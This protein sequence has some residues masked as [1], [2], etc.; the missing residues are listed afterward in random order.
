MGKHSAPRPRAFDRIHGQ[1]TDKSADVLE[2][3]TSVDVETDVAHDETDVAHDEPDV[4]HD[5]AAEPA[6]AP[7]RARRRSVLR[8]ALFAVVTAA[9]VAGTLAFASL[10]KSVKLDV[11]GKTQTV[12]T[13]AADVSG[14]LADSGV[15]ASNKD[16]V[17]PTKSAV[18]KDG[19]TVTVTHARPLTL[20]IDGKKSVKWVAALT[21]NEALDQLGLNDHGVSASRGTRIPVGGE[22]LTLTAPKPITVTADG[23]TQ[24]V[25]TTA[26]TA[27]EAIT[28]AGIPLSETDELSVPRDTPVTAGLQVS[29]TRVSLSTVTEQRVLP[30]A[31][32]QQPDPNQYVGLQSVLTAGVNG[33]AAVTVQVQSTNGVQTSRTDLATAVLTPPVNAVVSV[34]AKEFPAN[35]NALNWNALSMCESTNNPKAVNKTNGKYFGLYQFSVAT[36]ASVGGSGNPVDAAPEEQ[37]ARAKMLYM[38]SGAGQWECG[39]HLSD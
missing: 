4:A 36:W 1:T 30:Y 21:V 29:V 11:D 12:S 2:S 10:S 18:I 25:L 27:A 37:L 13:Y 31:T 24:T 26:T 3:A 19:Q 22:S 5:E 39:S 20:N 33:L 7:T 35:V 38:R 16:L 23:Q 8:H 9:L 14:V 17:S 15:K 6:L 32:T 34:G 28:R